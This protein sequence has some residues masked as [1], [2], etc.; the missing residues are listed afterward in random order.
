MSIWTYIKSQMLKNPTQTICEKD[1]VM[2]F[3]E[4]V[5]YAELFG[6]NLNKSRRK[7]CGGFCYELTSTEKYVTIKYE[8]GTK[9]SRKKS[10]E[11]LK[12][13]KNC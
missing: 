6:K 1:A 10:K 13:W 5:V 12:L 7:T 11:G 3:E 4:C 2:T 9:A 8:K